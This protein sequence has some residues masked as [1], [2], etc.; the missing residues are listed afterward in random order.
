M[1]SRQKFLFASFFVL[2]VF[3]FTARADTVV[4]TG[5]TVVQVPLGDHTYDL[6]GDGFRAAGR[7]EFGRTPCIP[8]QPGTVH[9]FFTQFEGESALQSGPATYNGTDYALLFYAG[10]VTLTIGDISLPADGQTGLITLNLPFTLSGNLTAFPRSTFE[11]NFGPAVFS[12][13][14][15]GQGTA[16]FQFMSTVDPVFGQLYSIRSMTYNFQPAAVP[17][18]A[19]IVL[20]ATGLFGAGA[21]ARRRR[22][23]SQ[24]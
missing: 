23:A 24:P 5:G 4:I 10:R 16:V 3:A 9:D 12:V 14:L 13:N 17:E 7:G 11:S 18:P 6:R 19:T 8:C 20:L 22:R 1:R 15:T 21:A 2:C